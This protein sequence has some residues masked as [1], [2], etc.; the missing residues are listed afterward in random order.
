[1]VVLILIA[2]AY[3]CVA[4]ERPAR[5]EGALTDHV[6]VMPVRIAYI[7]RTEFKIPNTQAMGE[8]ILQRYP[9]VR[10]SAEPA[11]AIAS[12]IFDQA[13]FIE[14]RSTVVCAI[15]LAVGC[16]LCVSFGP[17]PAGVDEADAASAA[18]V[19]RTLRP[20]TVHARQHLCEHLSLHRLDHRTILSLRERERLV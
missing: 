17:R 11:K 12:L 15:F 7:S 18:L 2:W 3:T 13:I 6:Y 20:G 14:W 1:M 9:D 4:R 19:E 10:T 5:H 8:Y 16:A